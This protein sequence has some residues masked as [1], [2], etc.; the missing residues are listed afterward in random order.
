MNVIAPAAA[1]IGTARMSGPEKTSCC[2]PLMGG[3]PPDRAVSCGPVIHY[4][5]S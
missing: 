3:S 4:G 1:A 5:M 2:T